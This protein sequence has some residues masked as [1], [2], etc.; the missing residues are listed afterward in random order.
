MKTL[1]ASDSPSGSNS[2]SLPLSFPCKL[3]GLEGSVTL[4]EQIGAG[5]YGKVYLGRNADGKLRAVKCIPLRLFEGEPIQE[6][7]QSIPPPETEAE[8]LRLSKH[9]NVIKLYDS[10]LSNGN[11]WVRAK[12]E[13][14]SLSQ[15]NF[16][17]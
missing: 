12:I 10:M 2:F 4:L 6:A 11:I 14:A 15:P 9:S 16:T 5:S 17:F 3:P 1:R 7:G 8:M 13:C